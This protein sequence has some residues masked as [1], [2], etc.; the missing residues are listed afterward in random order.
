MGS[1]TLKTKCD[2]HL[3]ANNVRFPLSV[4][5]GTSFRM[6]CQLYSYLES[7]KRL[8]FLNLTDV[9]A[10]TKCRVGLDKFII[11]II[12]KKWRTLKV[13][14]S[15]RR[16]VVR[17]TIIYRHNHKRRETQ[18]C[19][20]VFV[21]RSDNNAKWPMTKDVNKRMAIGEKVLGNGRNHKRQGNEH[22]D[23]EEDV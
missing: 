5:Y 1:L 3:R 9:I 15:S 13:F 11:L 4:L 17:R 23:K 18:T 20:G 7:S 21:L 2:W 6:Y 14:R 22:E 12:V 16:Q 8:Y 10:E 19:R